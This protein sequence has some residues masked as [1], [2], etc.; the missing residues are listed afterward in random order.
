MRFAEWT[1]SLSVGVEKIDAQHKKLLE[2]INDLHDAVKAGK[3]GDVLGALFE[4]LST[5]VSTNFSTEEAFMERFSYPKAEGH[6]RA[7]DGFASKVLDLRT[8]SPNDATA[9]G[10][11]ALAYLKD[12]I[13]NHDVL[14]D[15]E[16]GEFLN[17]RGID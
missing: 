10:D 9:V 12:W 8:K 15:R 4:E 6:K 11:E 14:I 13:I 17:K 2:V 5:Y 1:D 3:G 16:L 7:H